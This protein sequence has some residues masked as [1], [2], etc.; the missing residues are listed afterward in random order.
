MKNPELLA[1]AGDLE[2]LRVALA[3]G[4]DAVYCGTPDFSLRVG[5]NKF[6][7][8]EI[9]QAVALCRAAKKKIY[10][11]VNTYPRDSE[12]KKLENFLT[13]IK[14]TPPDA[15]IFSDL[16]VL[17]VLQK[18]FPKIAKHLSVQANSV[19]SQ[20]VKMWGKLGVK[21]II[22]A[23][24]L[25]LK[26]IQTIVKANLKM[27][28]ETFVHGAI[29]MSYSGRCL[30]SNFLTGR[31]ANR[32]KCA[33]P[34]R[35]KYSLVEEKRA[36][37]FLPIEE[38]G[39]GSYILNSRDLCLIEKIS[40]LVKAGVCSFKIEGRNKTVGYL[41]TIVRA[42]RRALDDFA[43]GRKFDQN[44][45][46]EIQTTGNR[47]FTLGFFDGSL[48][49]LQNYERSAG[50][51]PQ[52]FLGLTEKWKDGFALLQPKNQLSKGV[53]IEAVPPVGELQKLEILELR[54]E[55]FTEIAI[56]HGGQKSKVW[57]KLKKELPVRTLIRKIN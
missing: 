17:S 27:E 21:R 39:Q 47:D 42:Y 41:A 36:G 20:T 11:T 10:L 28:F 38:D 1:P 6:G 43:A 15:F 24:E 49:N 44:L 48:K 16:G 51:N 25:S 14:S 19:N 2:K 32:G 50:E 4:A 22:L 3:F 31:D 53:K 9:R 55:K 7:V 46:H 37:E 26:E 45:W 54:D 8:P 13:K 57:V 12:F 29:C 33:Q 35:W 30:L 56:A 40:Q 52:N 34:C 18:Y 23:R 5:E